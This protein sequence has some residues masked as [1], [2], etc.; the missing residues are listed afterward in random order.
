MSEVEDEVGVSELKRV[1]FE[2]T[3]GERESDV[4]VVL[5]MYQCD[6][7]RKEEEKEEEKHLLLRCFE[8]ESWLNVPLTT[9]GSTIYVDLTNLGRIVTASNHLTSCY[10]SG[11]TITK[12]EISYF[13]RLDQGSLSIQ[14]MI[15]HHL[16][17]HPIALKFPVNPTRRALL[18]SDLIKTMLHEYPRKALHDE[19]LSLHHE[20][21]QTSMLSSLEPAPVGRRSTLPPLS[22]NSTSTRISTSRDSGSRQDDYADTHPL[23]DE[24]C[25]WRTFSVNDLLTPPFEGTL[26]KSTKNKTKNMADCLVHIRCRDSF[27]AIARTSIKVWPA[28]LVLGR[29]LAS[30]WKEFQHLSMVE[31]GCGTGVT[32]LTFLRSCQTTGRCGPKKYLFTDGTQVAVANTS[33]NVRANG[34]DGGGDG[35]EERTSVSCASLDWMDMR[36]HSESSYREVDVLV[37]ADL[38]YDPVVADVFTTEVVSRLLTAKDG[39]QRT[40]LVAASIRN[41][42]SWRDVL[43]MLARKHL[44]WEVLHTQLSPFGNGHKVEIANLSLL[45]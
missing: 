35:G 6:G 32:G 3:V 7:S 38:F 19:L 18:L 43:D 17:M 27:G 28:G 41:A 45:A 14:S 2:V 29:Y 40:C 8:K 1:E 16:L 25:Y 20:S 37:G 30:R 9:V 24:G 22:S 34:L 11:L 44:K 39:K 42:G 12:Q 33:F 13:F 10:L 4:T 21:K 26:P 15:Y 36:S 5:I 23:L 31:F